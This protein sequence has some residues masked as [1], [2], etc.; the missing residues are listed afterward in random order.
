MRA[1]RRQS[2]K[3][4]PVFFALSLLAA[5]CCHGDG[6]AI[7]ARQTINGLELTVFAS[8]SPLRAGPVDVSVLVQEGQTPLLDANVEVTWS[9][10]STPSAEWVPPCCAMESDAQ[11][12]PAVRAHSNNRFLYS[13]IVPMKSS[14]PSELVIK[15]ERGGR[16]ASLSCDLEVR[17][18][19]PR[20]L[21]FWPWLAFPPV[22]IA[23]FAIHQSLLRSRRKGDS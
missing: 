13:A 19:M 21:A 9:A 8:P 16:E 7:L 6:G 17:P 4:F 14:G 15:V 18:P 1:P 5:V 3:S 10:G 2:A 11:R 23:G 22:A 12:I 20:A